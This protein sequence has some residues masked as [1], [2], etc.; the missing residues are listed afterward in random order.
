MS[1][2][3]ALFNLDKRNL[4]LNPILTICICCLIVLICS[5]ITYLIHCL[6]Q[7]IYTNKCIN[8]LP[9]DITSDDKQLWINDRMLHDMRHISRTDNA[10]K[11]IRIYKKRKSKMC[12]ISLGKNNKK[13][14]FNY[15]K[16]NYYICRFFISL[17]LCAQKVSTLWN[18]SVCP[19]VYTITLHNYIRLC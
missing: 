10:Y 15:F 12:V 2:S 19:A 7:H 4:L 17:F 14:F 3:I 9:Q 13:T 6:F 1:R 8:E 5:I 16:L 11:L 18:R